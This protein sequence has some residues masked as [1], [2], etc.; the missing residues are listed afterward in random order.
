MIGRLDGACLGAFEDGRVLIAVRA[1]PVLG[2]LVWPTADVVTRRAVIVSEAL[3]WHD[4]PV[5]ILDTA[6]AFVLAL[7][8]TLDTFDDTVP[9]PSRLFVG[10]V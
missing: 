5:V 1:T 2:A 8:D 10:V 3:I 7:V 4:A 6:G 9:E